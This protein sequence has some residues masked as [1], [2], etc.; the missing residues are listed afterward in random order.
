MSEDPLVLLIAFHCHQPVGNFHSVYEQA[1]QQSY[2]PLVDA[3][4]RHP[5]I[6]CAMHFSGPLVEWLEEAHRELLEEVRQMV[7][8]GQV[9]LLSG[10]YGEPVLS[11]LPERDQ[12]GQ[13]AMMGECLRRWSTTRPVGAWVAERVWEPQLGRMYHQ[14][15]IRYVIVDDW[16]FTRAGYDL[17]QVQGYYLTEE[18]GHRVAVF[19]G[20]ETL[21]YAWPFKP[22]EDALAPLRKMWEH[23]HRVV[24]FADD[25]E[26][27]GMWPYTHE[28]VWGDRWFDKFLSALEAQPWVTTK[29]FRD[30]LKERAPTGRVYLPCASYREMEEWSGGYFK[31]FLVKYPEANDLWHRMLEVSD[32]LN[33]RSLRVTGRGTRRKKR[34]ALLAQARRALYRAKC[35]DAYWHGVFGGLYLHHLRAAAY[36]HLLEAEAC[37][38][39]IAGAPRAATAQAGDWNGDGRDEVKLRNR[40]TL[41]YWA[42]QEGGA[43]YAWEL[44]SPGVSL[45]ATLTRREEAYHLKLREHE[46]VGHAA[47]AAGGSPLSIHHLFRAKVAQPEKWLAYDTY[48]RASMIDHLVSPDLSGDKMIALEHTELGDFVEQPYAWALRRTPR[49]QTLVLRREGHVRFNG[50]ATPITVEKSVTLDR[51]APRWSIRYRVTP[52]AALRGPVAFGVEWNLAISDPALSS[53]GRRSI[54]RLLVMND[55]WAQVVLTWQV[56]RPATLLY[57]PIETVSGSEG[58]IEKTRQGLCLWWLWPLEGSSPL[59]VHLEVLATPRL[60]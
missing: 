29:R 26:K 34:Q 50:Q 51:A 47:P 30:V 6:R 57:G 15:G 27:F 43:C 25:G 36:R 45:T 37:L 2:R 7:R 24:T 5:R 13:L 33:A 8:R 40:S 20:S 10:G 12:A 18:A 55:H 48:R 46:P 56:D 9:E 31:N 54:D 39:Q 42:P 35:N 41:G 60:A 28:W 3:L 22:V 23:G 59:A 53:P 4:S 58:G 11:L 52:R 38:D 21:R 44:L 17:G 32:R 1:Y 16:H 19:P 49:G 14:A